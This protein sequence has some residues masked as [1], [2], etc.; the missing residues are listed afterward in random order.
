M[1]NKQSKQCASVLALGIA[2]TT[3]GCAADTTSDADSVEL[4]P[5]AERVDIKSDACGS[6]S[7]GNSFQTNECGRTVCYQ[8]QWTCSRVLTLSGWQYFWDRTTI[9]SEIITDQYTPL[10]P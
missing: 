8:V 3:A 9:G 10:D 5:E 6:G 4:R 2:F 7:L 1:W